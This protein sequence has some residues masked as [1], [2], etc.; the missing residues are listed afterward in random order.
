MSSATFLPT[1]AEATAAG[2]FPGRHT[3]A[4]GLEVSLRMEQARMAESALG[5]GT[6]GQCHAEQPY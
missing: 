2:Y 3:V 6:G 5:H 4:D 1:V